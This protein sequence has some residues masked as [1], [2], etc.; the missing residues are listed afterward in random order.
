MSKP[1]VTVASLIEILKTHDQEAIIQVLVHTD[2]SGYYDQGGW[3]SAED[4]DP[5]K[6]I[7]YTDFRG[8]QFTTPD[9]DH[10]NKRF[11]LLGEKA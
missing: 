9:R 11:L 8:N 7:E 5:S 1:K 4:L 2:G 10:Y 6:H 3:C